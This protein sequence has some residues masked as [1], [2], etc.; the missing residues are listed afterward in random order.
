[1]DGSFGESSTAKSSKVFAKDETFQ[2]FLDFQT[3]G[4]VED[5]RASSPSSTCSGAPNSSRSSMSD[6]MDIMLYK[7]GEIP[8]SPLR[9]M[10]QSHK[11]DDSISWL[12]AD[13]NLCIA[14]PGM[15][16]G[17]LPSVLNK[18]EVS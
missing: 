10:M 14:F 9:K 5:S 13:E 8:S 11:K 4:A 7:V 6:S 16:Q 1:M 17:I 12:S 3:L 2:L 15:W 18:F